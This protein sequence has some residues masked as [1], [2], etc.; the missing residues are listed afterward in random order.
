MVVGGGAP[1]HRYNVAFMPSLRARFDMGPRG[2]G[3]F[4]G[5]VGAVSPPPP[6]HA[7]RLLRLCSAS[8]ATV[9]RW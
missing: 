8:L 1:V 4:M 5:L 2:F 3:S 6:P 7:G 9:D